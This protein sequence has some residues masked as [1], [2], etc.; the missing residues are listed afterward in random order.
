MRPARVRVGYRPERLH[1]EVSDDG[2]GTSGG[3]PAPG[4]HHGHGIAGMRERAALYGGE[5]H[6][7]P[8]DDGGYT[9]RVSL[10][11]TRPTT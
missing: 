3:T 4:G 7:G 11:I 10:P 9:V 1:V 5:L 8:G 2:R 6:A